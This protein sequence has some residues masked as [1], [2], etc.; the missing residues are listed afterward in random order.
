MRRDGLQG[1]APRLPCFII[2]MSGPAL[3]GFASNDSAEYR[4]YL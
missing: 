2:E 3:Q 4:V 1:K